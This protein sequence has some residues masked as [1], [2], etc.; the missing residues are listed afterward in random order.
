MRPKVRSSRTAEAQ[1]KVSRG[2]SNWFPQGRGNSR[3]ISRSKSRKRMATKKNR[4]E[5]GRRADPNGSNPHS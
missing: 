3:A 4:S 5:N 2:D 1:R